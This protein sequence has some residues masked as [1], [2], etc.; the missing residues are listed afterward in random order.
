MAGCLP[1]ASHS[2]WSGVKGLRV[3]ILTGL[4]A[5]AVFRVDNL[6]PCPL[7]SLWKWEPGVLAPTL[8][9]AGP[10]AVWPLPGPGPQIPACA[11]ASELLSDKALEVCLEPRTHSHPGPQNPPW[12]QILSL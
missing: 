10:S 11:Q 9:G 5:R 8:E 3:P 12:A 2:S 1:H 7:G 6:L 4:G